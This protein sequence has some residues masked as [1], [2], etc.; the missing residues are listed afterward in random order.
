VGSWTA[1]P[2]LARHWFLLALAVAVAAPIY[3]PEALRP[4]HTFVDPGRNV[5]AV[6][7]INGLTLDGRRILNSLRVPG[8]VLSGVLIGYAV[9][10]V[11]GFGASR[12]LLETNRSLAL[13]VLVISAMPT[14]LAS[15]II[16]TR[17]ARG[18][19]ALALVMVVTSNG[20]G[21]LLTPLIL[22]LTIG[23]FMTLS[24]EEMMG[25]FALVVLAPLALGQGL[26][27]AGPV[28]RIVHRQA[29]TLSH[30][31]RLLIL[32]AVS[33]AVVSGVT[34]VEAGRGEMS[35]WELAAVSL[36][37]VAVHGAAAALC[38]SLGGILGWNREDRTALLFCGSQKTLPAALY[39]S[40]EFLPGFGLVPIPCVLYHVGQLMLD[41]W[42]VEAIRSGGES[43]ASHKNRR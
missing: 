33:G 8:R 19:A 11:L 22:F 18:N 2:F 7:L 42:L 29:R 28:V 17:M 23:T 27:L 35:G 3:W 12:L 21:F 39:V 43:P 40:T 32:L 38:W 34:D 1:S 20:L 30:A 4:L 16:W 15:S 10:A 6:M 5:A 14:T 26:R 24:L 37:T 36:V 9:V 13:G 31:S 25:G 41:S